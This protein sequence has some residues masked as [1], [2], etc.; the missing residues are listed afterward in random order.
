M[1][2]Q[3]IT[4]GFDW[5]RAC[6]DLPFAWGRPEHSGSIKLVPEDFEVE[7]VLGFAPDGKG[8]HL[9]LWLE[10][11][12]QTTHETQQ[13]LA[14]AF[15]VPAAEVGFCG[16]KDKQAVTRQWFSLRTP[17]DPERETLPPLPD[18]IEIVQ[19]QRN[20]RKLKIGSHRGNRFRIVVR[21]LKGPHD[22]LRQRLELLAEAGIPNYFGPQRFGNGCSSLL[23]A[24]AWMSAGARSKRGP[25]RTQRGILL[26]AAR[27]FL[28]NRVLA[29]RVRRG[30]WNRALQGEL[31][32]LEGSA[33]VF[34]AHKAT[35]EELQARLAAMDIHPTGPLWGAGAA[36][37]TE[38]CATLEADVTA[39]CPVLADAL[40]REGLQQDRRALRAG[41][42]RLHWEFSDGDLLLEFSLGKGSYA[43]SVLRELVEVPL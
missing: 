8:E 5:A 17:F 25:S 16:M 40:A 22:A 31:L 19:A 34:P 28:F 30:D 18:G 7:E 4:T 36:R 29:E 33:S 41:V 27:S 9:C 6:N 10:K 14:R 39:T 37:V 2:S 11:R 35:P 1:A 24:V 23:Q 3:T 26:S 38:E 12:Q 15:S 43:T 13:A 42:E 32:A 20:S 21:E